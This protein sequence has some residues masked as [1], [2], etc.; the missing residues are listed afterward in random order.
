M[1][2]GVVRA[3]SAALDCPPGAGCAASL[4]SSH[5]ARIQVAKSSP[6]HALG[7]RRQA[8]KTCHASLPSQLLPRAG[9]GRRLLK[10][11]ARIDRRPGAHP[12]PRDAQGAPQPARAAVG[13]PRPCNP[14]PLLADLWE[15]PNI[16]VDIVVDM[17]ANMGAFA[18]QRG[19]PP[20][21]SAT[22]TA[23][24]DVRCVCS[25]WLRKWWSREELIV[26]IL[27]RILAWIA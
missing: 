9:L 4:R 5:E 21:A 11:L 14:P 20:L 2:G 23:T 8:R 27:P 17:G 19:A 22:A 6:K 25:H 18:Q 13:L 1:G 24:A 10:E 12:R 7:C 16:G 26:A 15:H 3:A